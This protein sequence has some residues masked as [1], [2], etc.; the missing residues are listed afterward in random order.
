[1]IGQ[2]TLRNK[3]RTG[4]YITHW[5]VPR[6]IQPAAFP[7]GGELAILE[8]APRVASGL[9][10]HVTNGMSEHA[11][12]TEDGVVR[13][14]LYVYTRE[15]TARAAGVLRALA[16]Y[17]FQHNTYF[18]DFDT[19][20]LAEAAEPRLVPFSGVLLAPGGPEEAQTLSEIHGV[21][22][23]PVFVHLVLPIHR[24][25][26]QLAIE[27]GGRELWSKLLSS[28]AMLA[29]DADRPTVV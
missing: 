18:A 8:F 6:D 3:A 24:A 29:L 22:N 20:P 1:M 17:P 2:L 23:E 28:E 26:M 11:Q 4:H 12:R 14:E 13:T 9:W 25:E 21:A 15:P 27:M 7:A 16:A 5:G 10:R 19:V